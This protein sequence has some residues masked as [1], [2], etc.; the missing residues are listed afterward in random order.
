MAKDTIIQELRTWLQQQPAHTHTAIGARAK[1]R[2]FPTILAYMTVEDGYEERENLAL[3]TGYAT[4]ASTVY[5]ATSENDAALSKAHR[6]ALRMANSA[7]ND[8]NGYPNSTINRMALA[9]A[10]YP[11]QHVARSI[12]SEGWRAVAYA[13]IAYGNHT[14]DDSCAAAIT[15]AKMFEQ[16]PPIATFTRNLWNDKTCPP[17]SAADWQRFLASDLSK[18]PEWFFWRE[19]YQGFVDNNPMDWNIQR[20]IALIPANEWQLGA[21]HIADLITEIMS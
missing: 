16:A 20:N 6:A 5:G 7:A 1:L 18:Q 21:A 8:A 19:W 2:G 17:V 9:S 10:I 4:L 13:A 14:Y 12:S 3:V 15:D 11:A